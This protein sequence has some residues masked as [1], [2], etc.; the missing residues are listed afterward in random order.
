METT[1]ILKVIFVSRFTIIIVH[2][3][4]CCFPKHLLFVHWDIE[5]CFLLHTVHMF[6]FSYSCCVKW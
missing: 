3:S 1:L 6:M 5:L 4:P 2:V